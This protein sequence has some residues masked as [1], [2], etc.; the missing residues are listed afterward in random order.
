MIGQRPARS[1]VHGAGERTGALPEADPRLELGS[2]VHDFNNFLTPIVSIMEEL[3]RQKVGS[4]T[5]HARIDG[6]ILC[7]FR[8]QAL[9]R[10]LLGPSCAREARPG[11]VDIG[12]LLASLKPVM[13]SVLPDQTELLFDIA[14]DLPPAFVDREL[15]ERALLNL[16]LNARDA[17]PDGGEVTV[18]A[19]NWAGLHEPMIRLSVVDTGI[20]MDPV[21]ARRARVPYFSTKGSGTGLGLAMVART[22]EAQGGRLALT[23]IAGHGTAIDLWLPLVPSPSGLRIESSNRRPCCKDSEL[24]SRGTG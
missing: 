6:A 24:S 13:E 21:T 19:V 7:A 17:M 2:I 3:K 20:G 18:A 14:D 1:Q 11:T 4:P 23:S 8:A 9:A 12:Q 10:Q 5:Q 15:L 16:I 22:M